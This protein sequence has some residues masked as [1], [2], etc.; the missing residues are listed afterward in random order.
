MPSFIVNKT[1]AFTMFLAAALAF[2]TAIPHAHA[3]PLAETSGASMSENPFSARVLPSGPGSAYFNPALL[4]QGHSSVQLGTL[5]IVQD[6]DI[7]LMPRPNDV[8]VDRAIYDARV[9]NPDGSTSRLPI[10]PLPTADLRNARGSLDPDHHSLFLV[11]GVVIEPVPDTLALGVYAVVPTRAFQTQTSAFVDEREQYFENSL[12]FERY[13][14]NFDTNVISMAAGVRPIHWARVGVGVTMTTQGYADNLVFVPDASDQGDMYLSTNV[15]VETRFRPHAGIAIEPLENLLLTSTLHLPSY[16]DVTGSNDL[17]L[18]NF[19]YPDGQDSFVQSYAYRTQ[20]SPLR[21]SIGAAY[22]ITGPTEPGIGV[23]GSL[24]YARWS[25][26]LDRHH[27]APLDAWLDTLSAAL[28]ARWHG[29]THRV[30]ADVVFEPSPVPDQVGRTNYVDNDR[31]G[32]A[33]AYGVTWNVE[34]MTLETGLQLQLHR[35]LARSIHKSPRATHPIVDEFPSSVDGRTGEAIPSSAGLQ[36][37]NPGY[38]G[39]A[40]DGWIVGGGLSVTARFEAPS[41]G[42]GR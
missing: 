2:P 3:S 31:L 26:Y 8:D 28:G 17:Q 32:G 7:E 15:R 5:L 12:D 41:E 23:A 27:Q 39:F 18:W 29:S 40:S 21:A 16:N 36:T 11:G 38:P 19:E 14:Q 42:D 10:R 9:P 22:G 25:E 24:T 35:L 4:P 1:G 34:G 13:G 30:G 20:T 37:N 6:L 33:L